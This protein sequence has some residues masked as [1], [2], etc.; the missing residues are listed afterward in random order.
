VSTA[1]EAR[2]VWRSPSLD[3]RIARRLVSLGESGVGGC[4]AWGEDTKGVWLARRS[5]RRTLDALAR[6]ERREWH[7]AITIVRDVARALAECERSSLS[8]GALRAS[9][10]VED[11]GGAWLRAESLVRAIAGLPADDAGGAT[12]RGDR[13]PA[14]TPPA[15]AAGEPWDARANRYVLGLVAYRLIAGSLP[16]RGAGARHAL[17]DAAFRDPPPFDDAIARTLRPGVQSLVLSMLA[18]DPRARPSDAAA[19]ALACEELLDDRPASKPPVAP[20]EKPPTIYSGPPT[21]IYSGAR[22]AERPRAL[23]VALP[24]VLAALAIA[25]LAAFSPSA[26]QSAPRPAIRPARLAGTTPADCVGCHSREVAEWERSVMAHAAKSPLFG[27]LESAVE[28]QIGRDARCPNGA[29]VLRKAGA[30]VCRDERSGLATTASGGEHWCVSCHAPGENLRASGGAAMPAWNA[31]GAGAARAPLRDLLPPSTM[32]GISC[33]S[34]HTTVGPVAAHA[35]RGGYEGNPTWTSAVSGAIFAMRPEDRDGRVGI[36]N[37]GYFLDPAILFGGRDALVHARVPSATARYTESSEFCG[38]CHDVRLF[39]TDVLGARDRGEHFKRLRNAYS[40]WRAWA[41]DERR[42]GRAPAS[43]QDCHM[44]QFPGVC[45]SD[46]SATAT[47]ECPAGTRFEERAPGTFARGRVAP[48][49]ETA[50]RIASHFFTSVDLPLTPTFPEAWASDTTLDASGAPLGLRARRDALLRRTFRLAIDGARSRGAEIEIP[51][52]IENTGAGHRVPAGFSQE[53]EIWIELVVTDARGRIVYEVGKV[54]ANDADLRDKAFL[55][56]STS[57]ALSDDRGRPLGLFGA[58]VADGPDVPQ[59]SPSPA[60]G[61]TR[62]RGRGL[63]NLQN[64]FLRCVKCIGV[65]DANG[66]CQPGI[67]QGATRADRFDDAVYDVDTGECRSNLRDGNELFET[68]FPI[69]ALDASRGITKAPDAII[70]TRSAPPGVTLTYTYVLPTASFAPPFDVAARLRFRS[71]PPFLVR[72]F[73]DYER[74]QAAAGKRP[75][76]PQ[77]TLDMLKRIEIVD[78]AAARVRLP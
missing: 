37:S 27:A 42:R 52:A 39:G 60:R 57:D 28:E 51:I 68:Y 61:G 23:K 9:D 21:T 72:A 44:S 69:G 12:P 7:G 4:F 38:A 5:V 62:F 45:V 53:R 30:D 75:S 17:G 11:G 48:S 50:A 78:L 77:V 71:F 43:C 76:G 40:E 10:I 1:D 54:S 13:A 55:R 3:A 58:D 46:A 67:G 22:S 34:C 47:A 63:V 31:L 74:N 65:I 64:G 20:R 70:D 16:F 19:M 41:E 2:D 8:P 15:Q 6:G 18:I 36:A 49:S 73:A 24:L 56:V 14:W 33:A 35:L 29:G 66:R 59:W 26:P 25:A 32:D